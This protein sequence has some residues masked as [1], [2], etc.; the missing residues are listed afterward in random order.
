MSIFFEF[1]GDS[2]IQLGLQTIAF[3]LVLTKYS[4]VPSSSIWHQL[5]KIEE[6]KREER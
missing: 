5:R 1:L 2:N 3:F 6:I 4:W